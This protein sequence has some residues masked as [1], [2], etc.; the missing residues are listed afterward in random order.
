MDPEWKDSI[1]RQYSGQSDSPLKEVFNVKENKMKEFDYKAYVTD[2]WLL[3]EAVDS[4]NQE[5][6]VGDSVMVKGRKGT[7][8]PTEVTGFAQGGD[9][10]YVKIS[11]IEIDGKFT[12]MVGEWQVEKVDSINEAGAKKEAIEHRPST[13]VKRL[14]SILTREVQNL[15]SEDGII[16][17]RPAEMDLTYTSEDGFEIGAYI[18]SQGEDGEIYV[19]T[20]PEDDPMSEDD[21]ALTELPN[22]LQ[23][24]GASLH[25]VES[26]LDAMVEAVKSLPQ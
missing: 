15:Q 21:I 7:Y 9:E 5:L 22:F 14:I 25:E 6:Q 4:N 1:Y 26:L 2:N 17:L 8:G 23:E 24:S 10:Q 19:S 16:D 11:G 3:K 20:G 13:R 18:L 12:T